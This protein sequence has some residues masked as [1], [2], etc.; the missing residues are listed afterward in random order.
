MVVDR[1][2]VVQHLNCAVDE[3]RREAWS[4]K[5]TTF[6]KETTLKR[7]RWLWSRGGKPA[8][9]PALPSENLPHFWARSHREVGVS[10]AWSAL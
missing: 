9:L 6:K 1:F 7:T 4:E 8:R 2:H 3:V 10:A 5:E